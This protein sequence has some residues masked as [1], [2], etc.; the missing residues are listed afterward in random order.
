MGANV[1]SRPRTQRDILRTFVQVM[2]SQFD[3]VRR[4]QTPVTAL[5][6]PDTEE[7]TDS[8]PVRP[9]TTNPRSSPYGLVQL[10][11]YDSLPFLACPPRARSGRRVLS[12][13]LHP[14]L[15]FTLLRACSG[16]RRSPAGEHRYRA[17]R[18]TRRAGCCGPY[19]PSARGARPRSSPDVAGGR[20]TITYTGMYCCTDGNVACRC[21]E[22]AERRNGVEYF[23]RVPAP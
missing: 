5:E 17:G 3:S 12:A 2:G 11:S 23:R 1:F 18:S 21:P 15:Q 8:D 14:A 10:A 16:H 9:T 4:R 20:E 6:F 7:V 19:G 22:P 13:P